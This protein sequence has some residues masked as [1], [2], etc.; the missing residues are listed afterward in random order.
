MTHSNPRLISDTGN[1]DV[2]SD[3]YHEYKEDLRLAK[4]IG[5]SI[6][7]ILFASGVL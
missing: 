7:M 5:V 1:A 4:S 2:A 6:K 3:F